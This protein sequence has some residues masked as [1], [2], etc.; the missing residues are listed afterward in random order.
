MNEINP[1]LDGIL[2]TNTTLSR[3]DGLK[4]ELVY[5]GYQVGDLAKNKTFEDVVCLLLNRKLPTESE[6]EAMRAQLAVS[7]V[8]P[9]QVISALHSCIEA[10]PMA[11]LRTAVSMLGALDPESEDDSPEA[12]RRK[13][14]RLIGQV[15]AIVSAFNDIRNG[16]D[17]S[18]NNL[19]DDTS[20]HFMRSI[21]NEDPNQAMVRVFDACLT[22]HADH[23]FNAS[24]FTARATTSSMSDMHSAITSAIGSLKGPWHGGA[25]TRVMNML[26]SI[27]EEEN[28][29][30]FVED[31]FARKERIMG[32][33]HRVY[34]VLD[35]RA[36]VLRD[37]LESMT[38]QGADEKWLRMSDK[39]RA[40]LKERKG[41]EAN[42]DFYS[43]SLYYSMGI[44]SDLY[45]PVFAMARIAGWCAHVL[46]QKE[47]N[48]I[49]RPK[50]V[51]KGPE[52]LS[53]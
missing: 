3:V 49:M 19:E 32:F 42:V 5:C 25:N 31:C 34:K 20:S 41:L 23:G 45:T 4:G 37:M 2:V 11:A 36:I 53:T 22:L 38:G 7:R 15:T 50:S 18:V 13:A 1:G 10:D 26:L 24:T 17:I 52:G 28:V 27:G 47:D 9:S 43:A 14:L 29:E 46:E 30:K 44:E 12:N 51:Y 16:R 40:M 33:G 39:M 6:R 21:R 35:P 8:L 48:R